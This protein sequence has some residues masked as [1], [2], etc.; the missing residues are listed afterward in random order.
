MKGSKKREKKRG[1]GVCRED[2]E[3][4]A[5]VKS[6]QRGSRTL[7]TWEEDQIHQV[8]MES[9][10]RSLKALGVRWEHVPRMDNT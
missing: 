7:G 6:M 5:H 2:W 4:W 9:T 8:H 3:H 1:L 10:P